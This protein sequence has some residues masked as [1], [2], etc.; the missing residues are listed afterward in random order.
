MEAAPSSYPPTEILKTS[1]NCQNPLCQNSGR[2]SNVYSNNQILNQ[3]NGNFQS[4]RWL[5]GAGGD[6]SGRQFTAGREFQFG[7]TKSFGDGQC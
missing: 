5:I 2:L 3:E 4:V 6:G 1:R 7:M